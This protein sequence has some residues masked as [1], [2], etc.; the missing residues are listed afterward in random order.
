MLKRVVLN[1]IDA[2]L[3]NNTAGCLLKLPLQ[4]HLCVNI[5]QTITQV[6]IL[7]LVIFNPR[8]KKVRLLA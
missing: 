4:T 2:S 8:L 7:F 3:P 5:K 6:G 1:N